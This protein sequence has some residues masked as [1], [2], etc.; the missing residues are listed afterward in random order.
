MSALKPGSAVGAY[1]VVYAVGHAEHRT[2]YL[3]RKADAAALCWL[4]ESEMMLAHLVTLA[5][6][7]EFF[8]FAKKNYLAFPVEG[9][10]VGTLARIVDAFEPGFIGWRWVELARDIGYLHGNNI[11]YQRTFTLSLAKL[12]FNNQAKMFPLSDRTAT[13]DALIFPAPES[14]NGAVTPAGDVYSLGASLSFLLGKP[15]PDKSLTLPRRTSSHLSSAL[16]RVLRKATE[17]NPAKRFKDANAFAQALMSALPAPPKIVTK[18]QPQTSPRW[19]LYVLVLLLL[20]FVSSGALLWFTKFSTADF[21]MGLLSGANAAQS[22]SILP[23]Q[24]PAANSL[25]LDVVALEVTPPCTFSIK[26]QL[27]ADA[28]PL[29]E[30]TLFTPGVWAANQPLAPVEREMNQADGPGQ[31]RLRAVAPNFC[32]QGGLLRVGARV[33]SAMAAENYFYTLPVKN[34]KS[35]LEEL[36]IASIQFDT[37]K[38]PAVDAYVSVADAHAQSTALR[39]PFAVRVLQDG[40]PVNNFT[41]SPV[42]PSAVPL[43]VVLVMDVSGSM[44]GKPLQDARA[45]TTAF[46]SQLGPHDTVC[47]YSFSTE[48]REVHRCTTNKES[49]RAAVQTFVAD[50]DTAL[51]DVLKTVS[52]NHVQRAGR[53]AVILLS[54]GADTASQTPLDDALTNARAANLPVYTIGLTSKD[55]RGQVLQQIA[56]ATSGSYLEAPSSTDLDALYQRVRAQL[57]NQYLIHFDSNAPIRSQG[58]IQIEFRDGATVVTTSRMYVVTPNNP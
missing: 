35:N 31:Y 22:D 25:E 6:S 18:P 50:R 39:G 20:L 26:M 12:V 54:D 37:H 21:L 46:I 5:P 56:Q 3:A 52:A 28:Q 48:V 13:D 51:Y 14:G 49:L 33:G 10:S 8:A 44:K 42:D 55:F 36:S 19:S 16:A 1:R 53:Q 27:L 41:M 43:T 29:P 7:G 9:T 24:D 32:Q 57:Q 58:N 17:Q 15:L 30:G 11:A 38:Y 40:A 2:L 45:A 23:A 4:V 34:G 47:L